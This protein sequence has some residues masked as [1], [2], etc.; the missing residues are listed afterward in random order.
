[1]EKCVS[2]VSLTK[3]TDCVATTYDKC[4]G[5]SCP[6]YCSEKQAKL[7]EQKTYARLRSLP[8]EQQAGISG[9]YYDGKMPWLAG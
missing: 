7:A 9:T 3:R 2:N 4:G 1:M 5:V 8:W 6:F